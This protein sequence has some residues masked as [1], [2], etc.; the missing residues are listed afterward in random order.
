MI[1]RVQKTLSITLLL[2]MF[3]VPM[4]KIQAWTETDPPVQVMSVGGYMGDGEFNAPYKVAVDG[5]GNVYVVDPKNCRVQK[6]DSSG[7][8]ITKWGTCGT[9][10]DQFGSPYGII[11]DGVGDVYVTDVLGDRILKFDPNGTFVTTWGS[12]GTG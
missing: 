1:M 5:S 4:N 11:V 3:L 10:E 8:F 7:N 9:E 6:F 2:F 12:E